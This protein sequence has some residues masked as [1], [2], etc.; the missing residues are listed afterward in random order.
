MHSHQFESEWPLT[1]TQ[2]EDDDTSDAPED[3]AKRD[4]VV[5]S[6]EDVEMSSQ[7]ANVNDPLTTSRVASKSFTFDAAV[8]PV[9]QTKPMSQL[10]T[11]LVAPES[12]SIGANQRG[13][14]PSAEIQTTR[15]IKVDASC[16]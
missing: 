15:C 1:R 3:E 16:F 13:V 11:T 4:D 12:I 9:A 8:E 10:P 14:E 2:F 6:N 7:E 5:D